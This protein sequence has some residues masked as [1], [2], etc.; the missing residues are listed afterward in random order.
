MLSK[1]HNKLSVIDSRISSSQPA[2]I[3]ALFQDIPFDVIAE[4]SLQEQTEYPNIRS[5]FPLMPGEEIQMKW[6][7][8]TGRRLLNKSVAFVNTVVDYH[9]RYSEKE[10]VRCN[11]LDFGC[12]WGRLIR[13]FYKYIPQTQIYGVDAW[14]EP[15]NISLNLGVKANL[16]KTEEICTSLPFANVTFDI[17]ISFS[18]FTHLTQRAGDVAL[19]T[20]RKRIDSNGLLVI[21]IRPAHYW[22]EVK[23][24]KNLSVEDLIARHNQDGFAFFPT[25]PEPPK[26]R[27]VTLGAASMTLHY[28]EQEWCDW[29]VID[30]VTNQVDPFQRVVLLAPV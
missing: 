8:S 27:E 18:V 4:L 25:L 26:G 9:Q 21:S 5:F 17:A 23:H 11:L 10:L 14:Q 16:G 29:K 28:I 6:T 2:S 22:R 12:G 1:Y 30:S 3:P 15:L 24:I 19:S 20:I 7:G 13:W